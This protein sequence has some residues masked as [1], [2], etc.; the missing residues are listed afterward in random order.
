MEH[1]SD[2]VELVNQHSQAI[3]PVA[4]AEP[5]M[6]FGAPDPY[7]TGSKHSIYQSPA[8][9]KKNDILQYCNFLPP[10]PRD[11]LVDVPYLGEGCP[12]DAQSKQKPEGCFLVKNKVQNTIGFVC[13]DAGGSKDDLARGNQFG[14]SYDMD[15]DGL[16]KSKKAEYS[17][18]TPVQIPIQMRNPLV[19][20]DKSTTFYPT[21]LQSDNVDG[22]S[23]GAPSPYKGGVISMV[24]NY[25]DGQPTYVF[26]YRV[27]NPPGKEGLEGLEGQ[28]GQEHFSVMDPIENHFASVSAYPMPS[29]KAVLLFLLAVIFILAVMVANGTVKINFRNLLK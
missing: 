29:R 5:G 26:P 4:F 25:Q 7:G 6:P 17:I 22:K 8:H 9:N 13:K 2:L 15:V 10:S 27:L 1:S 11:P 18:E 24:Q 20:Y 16:S 19:K 21:Y 3:L 14:W 23:A 12:Y 28:E